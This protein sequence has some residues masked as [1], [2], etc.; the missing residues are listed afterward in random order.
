MS[1]IS[2]MSSSALAMNLSIMQE[3]ISMNII[4]T[5]AKAQQA[6]ADMLIQNSRQIDAL[7]ENSSVGSIDI[8]F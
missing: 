8:S 7:S 6:L 2:V 3:Q 4:K 5:N 1:E